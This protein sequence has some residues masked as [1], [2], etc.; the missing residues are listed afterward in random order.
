[1]LYCKLGEALAIAGRGEEA[2]VALKRAIGLGPRSAEVYDS[3]G[4][5]MQTMGRLDEACAAYKRVILFQ[6]NYGQLYLLPVGSARSQCTRLLG[7]NK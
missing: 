5:A 2:I 6:S 7:G 3:Q 4:L 1:V